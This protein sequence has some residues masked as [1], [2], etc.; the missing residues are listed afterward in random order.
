MW[1]AKMSYR[2][3]LVRGSVFERHYITELIKHV[4]PRFWSPVRPPLDF[5][6]SHLSRGK[7]MIYF[8]SFVSSAN[9]FIFLFLLLFRCF[10]C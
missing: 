7:A 4:F 5:C 8:S 9:W 6:S 2:K 10:A 3:N 1:L